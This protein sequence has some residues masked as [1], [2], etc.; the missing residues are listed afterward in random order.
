MKTTEDKKF[1]YL[2]LQNKPGALHPDESSMSKAL[3]RF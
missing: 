1:G 3:T 2:F